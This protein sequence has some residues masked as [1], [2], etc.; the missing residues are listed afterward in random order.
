M[1]LQWR[2]LCISICSSVCLTVSDHPRGALCVWLPN[3]WVEKTLVL[4]SSINLLNK[5]SSWAWH[6]LVG[7]LQPCQDSSAIQKRGVNHLLI[8]MAVLS[9]ARTQDTAKSPSRSE[10]VMSHTKSSHSTSYCWL[11]RWWWLPVQRQAPSSF[12]SS[13]LLSALC[14]CRWRSNQPQRHIY[15]SVWK[16]IRI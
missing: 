15:T 16:M 9:S 6:S 8:T 11:H 4:I 14:Q 10:V 7:P 1:S 12:Y 13:S 5:Y 3:H 2:C